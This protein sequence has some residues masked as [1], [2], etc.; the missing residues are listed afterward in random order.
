MNREDSRLVPLTIHVVRVYGNIIEAV[1][2]QLV[3]LD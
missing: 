1:Y 3:K 2:K